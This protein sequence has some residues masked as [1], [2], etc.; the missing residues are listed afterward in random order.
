[1]CT[2]EDCAEGD[3]Q[4]D[5]FRDWVSHEANTHRDAEWRSASPSGLSSEDLDI[6]L[7]SSKSSSQPQPPKLLAPNDTSR[8]ECPI[9]LE[10]NPTFHHIGLHLLKLALFALPNAVG[11]DGDT[12]MGDQG[13]NIANMDDQDS[14]LSWSVF[15]KVGMGSLHEDEKDG[16]WHEGDPETS[17]DVAPTEKATREDVLR[18]KNALQQADK[19]DGKGLDIKSFVAGLKPDDTLPYRKEANN[20]RPAPVVDGGEIISFY[21]RIEDLGPDYQKQFA[22]HGPHGYWVPPTIKTGYTTEST[23]YFRWLQGSMIHY[24]AN[25]AIVR[26][27]GPVYSA[28]TVFTQHPDT[29]HLLFVPIDAQKSD[30]LK[31]PGAWRPLSFRHVPV[32]KTQRSYSAVS[33]DGEHRYI[34]APGSPHWMPQLLPE[35]YDCQSGD[36]RLQTGLIGSIPLL[37]AL[38]AF[39]APS[40]YLLS[41][42][43]SCLDLGKWLPHEHM[44]PS[45]R[46]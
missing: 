25:D 17:K 8:Q 14:V 22:Q 34:A 27:L 12:I 24:P 45:G 1:M 3:Q 19:S 11:P 26:A 23:N 38:A 39:S 6:S 40:T 15:E 44:Y 31:Y 43:T 13:S 36:P 5:N 16:N 35:V 4:Y 46:R 10:E 21:I 20:N 32:G 29:P 7:E 9:C 28:A 30:V 37:I 41:V 33:A 18:F 42:L 2:Y